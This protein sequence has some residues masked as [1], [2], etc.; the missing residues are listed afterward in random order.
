MQRTSPGAG[1]PERTRTS[2]VAHHGRQG[3]RIEEQGQEAE[4]AEEA[5]RQLTG[6]RLRTQG[7]SFEATPLIEFEENQVSTPTSGVS[8]GE[9]AWQRN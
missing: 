5:R 8:L 9:V 6:G 1:W 3:T 4:E 2:E 7:P